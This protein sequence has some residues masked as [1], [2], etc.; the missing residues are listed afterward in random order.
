M[1]GAF[2][3]RVILLVVFILCIALVITGCDKTDIVEYDISFFYSDKSLN[4]C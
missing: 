3:R 1:K 4:D 2:V